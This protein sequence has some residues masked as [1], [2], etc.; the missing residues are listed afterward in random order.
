MQNFKFCR[1]LEDVHI[2]IHSTTGQSIE[3]VTKLFEKT[4]KSPFWEETETQTL[5][6]NKNSAVVVVIDWEELKSNVV[7]K[8]EFNGVIFYKKNG[9]ECLLPIEN[10]K[11][12]SLDTMGSEF[13]V[14]SSVPMGMYL[15]SFPSDCLL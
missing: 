11:L 9:K 15:L 5:K 12:S 3:Y 6:P 2:L 1:P 8:I 14:M 10:V 4:E 13:D 7:S